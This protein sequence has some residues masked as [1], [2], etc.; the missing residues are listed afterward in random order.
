MFVYVIDWIDLTWLVCLSV[1]LL[2]VIFF[3]DDRILYYWILFFFLSIDLSNDDLI[4]W[5]ILTHSLDPI[6]AVRYHHHHQWSIKKRRKNHCNGNK[7][8]QKFFLEALQFFFGS[9]FHFLMKMF[10]NFKNLQI[11]CERR[12]FQFCRWQQKK[13]VLHIWNMKIINITDF[14]EN[15]SNY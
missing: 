9:S 3:S 11:L 1:C 2:I 4:A 7:K 14:D 12:C 15:T 8:N 10:L 6:T 13:D 5:Q